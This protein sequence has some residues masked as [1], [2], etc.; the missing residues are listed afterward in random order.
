[1]NKKFS[2]NSV[3]SEGPYGEAHG[4]ARWRHCVDTN[5]ETTNLIYRSF[6]EAIHILALKGREILAQGVEAQLQALGSQTSSCKALKGRKMIRSRHL[7]A[8]VGM[9]IGDFY[10]N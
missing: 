6:S 8:R 7:H 10:E 1:M 9:S 5:V 3:R 2:A 4:A